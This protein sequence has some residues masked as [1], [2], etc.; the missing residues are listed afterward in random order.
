[1]GLIGVSD[2]EVVGLIHKY[3]IDRRVICIGMGIRSMCVYVYIGIW[4]SGVGESLIGG[5]IIWHRGGGLNKV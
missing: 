4:Y 2:I 1:V 5:C 3:G